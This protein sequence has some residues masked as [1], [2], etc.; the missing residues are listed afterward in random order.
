VRK[1]ACRFDEGWLAKVAIS[2]S[3]QPSTL[4]KDSDPEDLPLMVPI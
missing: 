1:N 3:N 4:A 2:G